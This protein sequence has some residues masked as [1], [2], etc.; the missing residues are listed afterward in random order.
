MEVTMKRIITVQHTQA[1]HHLNGMVGSWTDWE[2]TDQGKRQADNIGKRLASELAGET[3]KIYSSDLIRA[4]QTAEPFAQF[5]NAAIEFRTDLREINIG[6]A[7]GKS[8]QWLKENQSSDPF[9][10]DYRS[11]PNAESGR[12]VWKRISNFCCETLASADKTS[13]DEINADENICGWN[14]VI[15]SHG[16]VLS[17]FPVVFLGLDISFYETADFFGRAGGVSFMEIADDGKKILRRYNDT[18][19]MM[20]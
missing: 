2:L 13:A 20:D 8:V 18:A 6:D 16:C 12:D 3:V 7:C 11:F 19:Y 17:I 9:D 15:F 10:I 1:V 4:R 5:S 14:I